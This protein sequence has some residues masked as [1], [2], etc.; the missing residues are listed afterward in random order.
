M[1]FGSTRD[2]LLGRVAKLPKK[3][4]LL[5]L[6]LT[7]LILSASVPKADAIVCARGVYRAGC[8]GPRGGFVVGRPY[9]NY[10]RGGYYHG[11]YWRGGVRI[12][13]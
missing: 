9:Y 7:A 3:Q 1:T 5:L 10:Y 4:I 6:G 2:G 12:C 13:R 8:V 11:C